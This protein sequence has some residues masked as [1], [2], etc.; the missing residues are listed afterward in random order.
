MQRKGCLCHLLW[1]SVSIQKRLGLSIFFYVYH[2]AIINDTV[3]QM[4]VKDTVLFA[5]MLAT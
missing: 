4:L 3:Y 5:G 1:G 2:I